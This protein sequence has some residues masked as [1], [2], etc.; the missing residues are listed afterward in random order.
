MQKETTAARSAAASPSR[1]PV[2][3]LTPPSTV[4]SRSAPPPRPRRSGPRRPG[5]P[6]TPAKREHER[7]P[8]ARGANTRGASSRGR[9]WRG[10]VGRS[11]RHPPFAEDLFAGQLLR[12]ALSDA[13]ADLAFLLL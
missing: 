7:V 3:A 5:P 10:G 4:A 13:I 2:V 1:L 6:H 9:G 12:H 11:S 8:R